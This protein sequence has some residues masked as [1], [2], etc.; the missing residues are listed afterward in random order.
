M[1]LIQ[2]IMVWKKQ[3]QKQF[4]TLAKMTQMQTQEDADPIQIQAK[5]NEILAQYRSADAVLIKYRLDVDL[6]IKYRFDANPTPGLTAIPVQFR[7]GIKY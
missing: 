2:D 3:Y 1:C 5:G 7:P 4:P 6:L